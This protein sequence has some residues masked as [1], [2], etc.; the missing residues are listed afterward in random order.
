MKKQK[1]IP[2]TI[3][4]KY[5]IHKL[6]LTKKE[7]KMSLSNYVNYCVEKEVNNK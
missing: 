4:L 7:K 6:A 3:R 5:N 2:L 1:R